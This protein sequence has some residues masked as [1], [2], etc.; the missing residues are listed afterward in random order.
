MQFIPNYISRANGETEVTYA[1]EELESILKPT[2]GVV[3]YQESVM[4]ITKVLGG[5]SSGAADLFRKAIGKKSQKVM[6]EELPKLHK[7]IMDNGYSKDIADEVQNIIEPFI[8]YGFNKS[9]AAAYSLVAYYTAYL[10]TYYPLE[11]YIGNLIVSSDNI[12]KITELINDARRNDLVIHQPNINTSQRGFSAL[13][14][15]DIIYGFEAIKSLNKNDINKILKT[16][17]YDSVDD[18]V[19]KIRK[20]N[21]L[22]KRSLSG[23]VYSGCF[24]TLEGLEGLSRAEIEIKL[25][26][27]LDKDI[28]SLVPYVSDFDNAK[29]ARLE[30][31][32]LGTYINGHPLASYTK[33]I[34][35]DDYIGEDKQFSTLAE[36]TSIKAIV[37][38]KGDP[39]AFIGLSMPDLEV[40]AVCFPYLWDEST[41]QLGKKRPKVLYKHILNEGVTV[42]VRGKIEEGRNGLSVIIG[43]LSVP[44]KYNKDYYD[45]FNEI[46]NKHGIVLEETEETEEVNHDIDYSS[47]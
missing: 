13:S 8:G 2:F 16:R 6:D 33:P 41:I 31:E 39:M 3:V 23:L 12:D 25:M 36:I 1:T 38:K 20:E 10:K 5:Y 30:K 11:F 43:N 19:F 44:L 18:F 45:L 24:D 21:N 47:F 34:N 4:E 7:S 26:T 32:Y 9:H 27:M 40:D 14:D 37:T 35:W 15:T 29:K 42:R 17:P 22:N 46:E 28:S